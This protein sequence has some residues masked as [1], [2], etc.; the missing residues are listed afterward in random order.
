MRRILTFLLTLL[1][2]TSCLPA[3]STPDLLPTVPPVYTA[4]PTPFQPPTATITPVVAQE[5]S[6][7]PLPRPPP[8]LR[9]VYY[10]RMRWLCIAAFP[11]VTEPVRER[12]LT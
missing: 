9:A 6:V 7:T 5:P 8:E 3:V 11:A 2:L 10:R 12:E 1:L 4:T